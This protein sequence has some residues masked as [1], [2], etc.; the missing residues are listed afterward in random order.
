[1]RTLD[2]NYSRHCQ[3]ENVYIY[4]LCLLGQM[5]TIPFAKFDEFLHIPLR[6][7]VQGVHIK[8]LQMEKVFMR[9]PDIHDKILSKH[10]LT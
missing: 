3:T 8:L 9:T 7:I 5:E 2:V 1:M 4:I 10:T 6:F